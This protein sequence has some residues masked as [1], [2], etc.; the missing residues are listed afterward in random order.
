[1]PGIAVGRFLWWVFIKNMLC[2]MNKSK[3]F[4]PHSNGSVLAHFSWLCT[5][6]CD[7]DSLKLAF[8]SPLQRPYSHHGKAVARQLFWRLHKSVW[9]DK[10]CIRQCPVG[11]L[12][13]FWLGGFFFFFL[14]LVE[15]WWQAHRENRLV[16]AKEGRGKDGLGIWVGRCQL[17]CIEKMDHKG[18]LYSTIGNYS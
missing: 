17:L 16:V 7:V 4:L 3:T 11:L 8:C 9:K 13:I 5:L 2:N 15:L 12:P 1:M 6:R 18:L 14:F 10:V